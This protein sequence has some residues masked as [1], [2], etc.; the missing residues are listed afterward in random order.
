[1]GEN[2]QVDFRSDSKSI[3]AIADLRIVEAKGGDLGFSFE[4]ATGY[5][6]FDT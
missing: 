5:G 3:H 6:I 1:M 2:R 4:T